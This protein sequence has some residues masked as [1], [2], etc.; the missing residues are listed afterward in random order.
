MLI[1]LNQNYKEYFHTLFDIAVKMDI[2]MYDF[3]PNST[4]LKHC[5]QI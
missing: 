5:N 1:Y 4:A 3:L 2:V